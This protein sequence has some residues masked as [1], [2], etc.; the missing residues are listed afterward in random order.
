MGDSTMGTPMPMKLPS[1]QVV[2][3]RVSDDWQDDDEEPENPDADDVAAPADDADVTAPVPPPSAGGVA[4]PG[5][6]PAYDGG[7]GSGGYGSGGYGS[8]TGGGYGSGS[9]GYGSSSGGYGSGGYGSPTP[10]W[11]QPPQPPQQGSQ[12]GSPTPPSPY[13]D[14]GHPQAAPQPSPTADAPPKQRGHLGLRKRKPAPAIDAAPQQLHGFTDAVSGIA[15]SVRAGLSK[16]APD[17]VE[18]EF[19]LDI[20]VASGVA[21]SL[22]ADARAKA[23]VR[24]KLGWAN[25]GPARLDGGGDDFEKFLDSAG[26]TAKG[27][28]AEN[29]VAQDDSA[30]DEVAEQVGAVADTGSEVTD[31]A[32]T[33]AVA[34]TG[35]PAR[36]DR[37][38]LNPW[39]LSSS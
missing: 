38:P 32:T 12:Q 2:W 29:S 13:P 7:Y 3:V 15:E 4:Q 23:A 31:D 14:Y 39:D 35:Y 18:I 36:E 5:G 24:I 22:I 28:E 26:R 16:A 20:D 1:G 9:G 30:Q 25:T 6:A 37:P 21:I 8:T 19:G 17:T 11:P 10:P 34:D 33:V 27:V